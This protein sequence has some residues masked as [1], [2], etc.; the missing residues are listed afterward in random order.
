MYTKTLVSLI[1]VCN[2]MKSPDPYGPINVKPAGGGRAE[3]G[4][5][6]FLRKC[7]SNSLL[8]GQYFPLNVPKLPTQGSMLKSNVSEVHWLFIASL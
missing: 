6:T 7:W 5:L 2:P 8:T 4:D 1:N 3:G